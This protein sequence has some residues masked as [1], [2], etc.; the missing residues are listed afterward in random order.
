M[1]AHGLLSAAI[2]SAAFASALLFTA[3]AA[4]WVLD[5]DPLEEESTEIG[6]V[7]RSFA[8]LSAGPVLEPPFAPPGVNPAAQSIF[9]ARLYGL[10]KTPDYRLV[11]HNQS[12]MSVTSFSALGGLN[13]GR[14]VPPPRFFPLTFDQESE[15]LLL[16]NMTDWLFAEWRRKS[17]TITVGRQPVTMGR[18]AVWHTN[19]LVSTFA[20]T[21]VNKQ[22]K[23]GADAVRL[24]WSL[25][26][27]QNLMVILALGSIE[28]SR[29][30]RLGADAS[31]STALLSYKKAG[32]AGEFGLM[33]G[34]V[35]GDAVVSLD[36]TT[37]LFGFD[38]YGEV[39]G[40]RRTEESLSAPAA[41]SDVFL[42]A[43]LGAS[44][45][46]TSELTIVP[47]VFYSGAG[48]ARPSEY[49]SVML[50][51]RFQI[52]DQTSVGRYYAS[53]SNLWQVSP[54]STLSWGMMSNLADPSALFFSALG[55]SLS[56]DVTGQVGFYAPIGRKP[57]TT[58]SLFS[59]VSL[60]SEF[61]TYP[62]F[63]FAQLC[64]T[65]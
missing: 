61:G 22:F 16:R 7:A 47:E 65:L 28:A 34:A 26:A 9:D 10:H 50:S 27:R 53:L 32:E 56:D 11:V 20:L 48:A 59:P 19:D 51:E 6:V 29:E 14:G 36:G 30:R 31:G 2:L 12:T 54:L 62:Y 44:F 5:E 17:V 3:P 39:T 33:A 43:L 15:G 24:D 64:A 55:Q 8:F 58:D 1:S 49:L 41:D 35:R 45:R 18:G 21:E 40:T 57:V 63:F 13:L 38:I 52:G 42:K 4:A 25:P 23:P 46:P 37:S 60:E